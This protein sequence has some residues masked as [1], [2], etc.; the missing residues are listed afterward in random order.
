MYGSGTHI[1]TL[2]LLFCLQF[3]S[4]RTTRR[5]GSRPRLL[6]AVE[7]PL[8]S[9]PV[10]RHLR[11]RPILRHLGPRA[12]S[13][14]QA[15]K[16]VPLPVIMPIG[17]EGRNSKIQL[18]NGPVSLVHLPRIASSMM[19]MMKPLRHPIKRIM[20]SI[21]LLPRLFVSIPLVRNTH[22]VRDRTPA[23]TTKDGDLKKSY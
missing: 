20:V 19:V 3:P 7:V 9:R 2:T 5:K 23:V 4:R 17:V 14:L 12:R 22:L 18:I 13:N 21:E 15:R 8:P 1:V 11:T 6:M 10:S 16:S